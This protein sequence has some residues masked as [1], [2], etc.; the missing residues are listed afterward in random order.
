M[1][2]VC[3]CVLHVCV[4]IGGDAYM[5]HVSDTGGREG[6]NE[7]SLL[8]VCCVICMLHVYVS[9][10]L[11]HVYVCCMYVYVSVAMSIDLFKYTN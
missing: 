10:V 8:S 11:C 1:C 5:L 4:Y 7:S 3:V 2:V 6:I 9:Y